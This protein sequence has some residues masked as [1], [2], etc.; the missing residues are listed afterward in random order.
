MASFGALKL[1]LVSSNLVR[2]AG[3]VGHGEEFGAGMAESW[4]AV[5]KACISH[6]SFSPVGGQPFL[7]QSG[8]GDFAVV[9]AADG[10]PSSAITTGAA[11]TAPRT[12]R[13]V[14]A[15]SDRRRRVILVSCAFMFFD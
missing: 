8:M 14:D 10:G 11:N 12:R 9:V 13:M 15:R 7:R 1:F 4:S 2:K 3:P 5:S 6:F